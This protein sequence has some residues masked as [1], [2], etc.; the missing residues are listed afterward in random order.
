LG[1][2]RSIGSIILTSIGGGTKLL[3]KTWW[4]VRKGRNEVKKSAREFYKTLRIGG[5]PE[6]NAKE[7]T[8][9]YARPAWEMLSVTNLIKMAMEMSD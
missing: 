2:V 5:I 1:K 3:A 8:L 6:E 9:A 4:S 7:I